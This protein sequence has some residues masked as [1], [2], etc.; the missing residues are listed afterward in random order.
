MVSFVYLYVFV[1]IGIVYLYL[2]L[3]LTCIAIWESVILSSTLKC[4][5]VCRSDFFFP[6]N[7]EWGKRR[8]GV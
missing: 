2:L 8:D 3:T 6:E 5:N 4:A 7:N 1:F